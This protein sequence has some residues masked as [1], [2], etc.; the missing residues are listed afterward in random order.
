MP[1]KRAGHLCFLISV[2]CG[3]QHFPVS[4]TPSCWDSPSSDCDWA[5][6]MPALPWCSWSFQVPRLER[7]LS[8]PSTAKKRQGWEEWVNSFL[9]LKGQFVWWLRQESDK[10]NLLFSSKSGLD[11]DPQ[12]K[13]T[14]QSP[15]IGRH[16]GDGRGR[17]PG[18]TSKP[19]MRWP[20]QRSASLLPYDACYTLFLLVLCFYEGSVCKTETAWDQGY[21]SSCQVGPAR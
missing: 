13:L 6:A 9:A 12:H 19:E 14:T 1:W 4:G 2:H 20:R 3:T 8:F 21:I 7:A 16:E 5:Q 10:K 18:G 11:I 17:L 15:N